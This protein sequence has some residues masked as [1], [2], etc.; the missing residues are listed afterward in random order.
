MFH[1]RSGIGQS[2]ILALLGTTI[3]FGAALPSSANSI[4]PLNFTPPEPENLHEFVRDRAAAVRLGKALFWDEQV[5]GDGDV[6]CATC[7]H[8]AGADSRI[9]NRVM[10]R[11]D[12]FQVTTGPG[13][14]LTI[15]DFPVHSNDVVGSGGVVARSLNGVVMGSPEDDCT[16]LPSLHGFRQTTGRDAPTSVNAIFNERQFWDGRAGPRFNGVDGSGDTSRRVVEVRDGE[17]H[18]ISLVDDLE[19]NSA[20][21]ANQAVGPPLSDVEMSCAGRSFPQ[22]GA[23]LLSLK[24]LGQQIVHPEDSHLG[25]LAQE[26]DGGISTTYAEMIRKAFHERWWDSDQIIRFDSDGNPSVGE[27]GAPANTNEFTVMEANFPLFWGL[28]IQLYETALVSDDTPF[29]RGELSDSARRGLRVFEGKARCDHC[30]DTALFTEAIFAGGSDDFT[31]TA[32]RP[33]HEDQGRGQGKFKTS[34]LRNVALTGPYFHNG[35]YLT[36]RDVVDFYDR[37][38]DFPNDET[39]SQIRQLELS[40]DEKNEL[41]QFML[42]L[43]DERVRCERAPFDHPSLFLPD[44]DPKPAVGHEGLNDCLEPVL[45][46]GNMFFHFRKAQDIAAAAGTAGG[47]P[48]LDSAS[49]ESSEETPVVG[50]EDEVVGVTPLDPEVENAPTPVPEPSTVLL[51]TVGALVMAAAARRRRFSA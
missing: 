10:P 16:D 50:S 2:S 19:L 9:I 20:S 40:N 39:D 47:D 4:E 51:Q 27:S 33:V 32:V 18:P 48:V 24:P 21:A 31:N 11:E 41:V 28:A 17:T 5:G 3:L 25:S 22:L 1:L 13:E 30:H 46:D 7:H 8:Q 26:G 38:G 44:G 12:G 42:E 35:G 15:S 6:A 49:E 34:G 43:T 29:D 45:S 14:M 36:L 23:K 37:G